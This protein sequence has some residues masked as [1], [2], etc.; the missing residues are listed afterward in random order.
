MIVYKLINWKVV[1]LN[2]ATAHSKIVILNLARYCSEQSKSS[3]LWGISYFY[4]PSL[5]SL[6]LKPS[7]NEVRKSFL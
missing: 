6:G 2:F 7:G 5:C 1:R 3:V 4:G